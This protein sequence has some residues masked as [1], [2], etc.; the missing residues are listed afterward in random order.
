MTAL[1]ALRA[2]TLIFPD[3]QSRRSALM[4]QRERFSQ[5]LGDRPGAESPIGSNHNSVGFLGACRR[6]WDTELI[7]PEP[8]ATYE[9]VL[10]VT[11]GQTERFIS[12]A[13]H[14]WLVVEK[15]WVETAQLAPGDRIVASGGTDL[16]VQSLTLTGRME[17]TFNLEVDGLHTFWSAKLVRW[18]TMSAG[19]LGRL[20]GLEIRSFTTSQNMERAWVLK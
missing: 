16:V 6:S 5:N 18:C 12:S 10:T 4:L 14:P 7:R 1:G 17:R 13:D 9:L 3:Q 20:R 8:Q 2:V 15:G 11:G 19:V